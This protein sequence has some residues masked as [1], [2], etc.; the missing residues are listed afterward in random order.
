MQALF[1]SL[2]TRSF[3]RL[4]AV[5]GTVGTIVSGLAA[6]WW[7]SRQSEPPLPAFPPPVPAPEPTILDKLWSKAAEAVTRKPVAAAVALVGLVVTGIGVELYRQFQNRRMIFDMIE[8]FYAA[9]VRGAPDGRGLPQLSK[10]DCAMLVMRR[11]TAYAAAVVTWTDD[12][13]VVVK[14]IRVMAFSCQH[15]VLGHGHA[16]DVI[17]GISVVFDF[18]GRRD[19][20]ADVVVAAIEFFHLVA[21]SGDDAVLP[22]IV[23][24]EMWRL[25]DEYPGR[26]SKLR[27][28][29]YLEHMRTIRYT[30]D[31]FSNRDASA[32]KP[33]QR[34]HRGFGDMR[35]VAE[36]EWVEH[37][38][39]LGLAVGC[40]ADDVTKAYRQ[41]ALQWHPD[42]NSD[43]VDEATAKLQE[44][45]AARD[46]LL[47][48][49]LRRQFASGR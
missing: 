12:E 22:F 33:R 28:A 20:R 4:A 18:L 1:T 46:A 44:L 45:N 36:L 37:H 38:R 41:L 16:S 19:P 17:D 8:D 35:S 39:T 10:A 32:N 2:A 5:G 48:E 11:A 24:P 15:G 3:G 30:I 29:P 26:Y 43:A 13:P 31:E 40:S 27:D 9:C 6:L 47:N 49:T 25:L 14:A 42:K 21:K 23:R 7:S 34:P